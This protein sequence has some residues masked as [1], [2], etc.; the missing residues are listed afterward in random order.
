[1]RRLVRTYLVCTF[2]S[3]RWKMTFFVIPERYSQG[4]KCTQSHWLCTPCQ[5]LATKIKVFQSAFKV[6]DLAAVGTCRQDWLPYWPKL[7]HFWAGVYYT[8]RS[9]GRTTQPA[10]LKRL[11]CV[12]IHMYSKVKYEFYF[13]KMCSL[14][15]IFVVCTWQMVSFLTNFFAGTPL[16]RRIVRQSEDCVLSNQAAPTCFGFA[17]DH[18]VRKTVLRHAVKL[19]MPKINKRSFGE[20]IILKTIFWLDCADIFWSQDWPCSNIKHMVIQRTICACH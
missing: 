9:A 18:A 1:M 6:E 14:I 19:R 8:L 16:H 15:L 20:P 12:R 17:P 10:C 7:M 4:K 3:T 2:A 11:I 5:K 13:N